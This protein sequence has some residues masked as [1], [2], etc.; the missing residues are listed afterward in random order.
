MSTFAS[1]IRYIAEIAN[2]K[3]ED[4]IKQLLGVELED[5]IREECLE[6]ARQGMLKATIGCSY[7]ALPQFLNIKKV[8]ISSKYLREH[9]SQLKSFVTKLL[10]KLGLTGN[11]TASDKYLTIELSWSRND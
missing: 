11:V 2:Q 9:T 5:K 7:S 1:E 3:V 4:D 6:M 8:N 10:H